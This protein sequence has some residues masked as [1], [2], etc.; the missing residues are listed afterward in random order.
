MKDVYV[1]WL[2]PKKRNF[3]GKV[4]RVVLLTLTIILGILALGLG[5]L[6]ILILA[7][8]M[9]F[10]TYF[11]FCLTDLEYEYIYVNGELMVDRIMQ[12]SMRKRMLNVDKSE[13]EVI[14]PMTSPKVDPYKNRQWKEFIFTSG[15]QKDNRRIFEIYCN[16]GI[17]V[18]FE[19]N[20]EMIMAMKSQMPHKVT[21]E[22]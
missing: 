18:V 16:N 21:V 12:K 14:A 2:I 22:D 15:Y 17:K 3:A 10:V 1:E 7:V 4:L 13:I 5:K 8:L 9:G 19:P 20:R 11:L 6:L